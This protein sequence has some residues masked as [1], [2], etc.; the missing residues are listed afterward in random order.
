MNYQ[1]NGANEH[2]HAEPERHFMQAKRSDVEHLIARCNSN[3]RMKGKATLVL[4]GSQIF[5]M[6]LR[7]EQPI[8]I[9][10]VEF[11]PEDGGNS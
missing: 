2:S 11:L 8:A 3:P 9:T 4:E 10:D 7:C 5:M 1:K 6:C